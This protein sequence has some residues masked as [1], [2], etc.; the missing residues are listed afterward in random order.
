MELKPQTASSASRT[1]NGFSERVVKL[2]E[3]M[4]SVWDECECAPAPPGVTT[5]TREECKACQHANWLERELHR[6]LKLEVWQFPAVTQPNGQPYDKSDSESQQRARDLEAA[7][8][9]RTKSLLRDDLERHPRKRRGD[10]YVYQQSG[11]SR[12]KPIKRQPG[13]DASNGWLSTTDL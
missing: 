12:F 3:L 9:E 4:L 1:F 8:I 5:Y 10:D 13:M 2:F 6:E 11:P 7:V